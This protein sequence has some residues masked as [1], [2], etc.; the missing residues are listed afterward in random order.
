MFLLEAACLREV[1][2]E[3][4]AYR[5][6]AVL[7][8]SAEPTPV[9]FVVVTALP[10][11]ILVVVSAPVGLSL[12]DSFDVDRVE[13]EV[14]GDVGV[15]FCPGAADDGVAVDEVAGLGQ[16]AVVEDLDGTRALP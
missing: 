8:S 9:G 16:V 5:V 6:L 15:G 11:E 12:L 14:F 10:G 13:V 2:L 3:E 7:E 4:F 1:I